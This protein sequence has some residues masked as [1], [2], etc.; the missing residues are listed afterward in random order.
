MNEENKCNTFTNEANKGNPFTNEANKGKDLRSHPRVAWKFVVKFR[1]KDKE[2]TEW[3]VST[4]RDISEN[5]CSFSSSVAYEVGK[6]LEIR[7]Q[8]PAFRMPIQFT[9]E[10]KRCESNQDNQISLYIIGIYFL[11]IDAEK[12]KEFVETISFFLKKKQN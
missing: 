9:G 10:V 7:V 4:I 6:V 8:L 11:E 1:L 12:K 5:G 3:Q 2:D